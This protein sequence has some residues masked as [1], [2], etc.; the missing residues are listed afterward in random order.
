MRKVSF[1]LAAVLSLGGLPGGATTLYQSATMGTSGQTSGVVVNANQ[2]LGAAFTLPSAAQIT[3]VGGHISGTGT[4]FAAI[5]SLSGSLPTGAPF[6][7]SLIT[8]TTFTAPATSQDV[9]VPLSVTLNAGTYALIFGSGLFGATGNGAMPT[10]NTDVVG[11][12]YFYWD[13]VDHFAWFL[14]TFSN[15]RFTVYGEIVPEPSSFG[16]M[17]VGV[18]MLL[19]VKARAWKRT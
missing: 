17:A 13:G 11:A 12:T 6:D 1:A 16:L 15:T 2:F 4:L 10:N 19:A 5:L 9:V 18:L 14:D 7:S 3:A 8:D